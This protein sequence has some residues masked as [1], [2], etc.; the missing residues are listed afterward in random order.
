MYYEY[1]LNG[2]MAHEKPRK[3]AKENQRRKPLD[4]TESERAI[5]R[6]KIFASE[7]F[8]MHNTALI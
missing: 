3:T 2:R 8:A 5:F 7:M 4:T 6:P 1:I